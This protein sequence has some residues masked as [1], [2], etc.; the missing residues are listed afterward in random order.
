MPCF[1]TH[2]KLVIFLVYSK[3]TSREGLRHVAIMR[4][5]EDGTILAHILHGLDWYIEKGGNA[6]R[7]P[8]KIMRDFYPPQASNPQVTFHHLNMLPTCT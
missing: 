4:S 8:D 2:I 6:P 7:A 3:I 5:D 1:R